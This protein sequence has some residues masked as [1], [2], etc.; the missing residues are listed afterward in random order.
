MTGP[1][2][3]VFPGP[4]GGYLDDSALRRR[5]KTARGQRRATATAVPRP[6]P[7]LR[8]P[9]HPH[10][11]PARTA[12]VDGPRRLRD[13][14]GLPVLHASRGRRPPTWR[15]VRPGP[16]G[17]IDHGPLTQPRALADE[18][19][20]IRATDTSDGATAQ[21]LA[22]SRA[23]VGRS[24]VWRRAMCGHR[25]GAPVWTDERR[26]GY[27]TMRARGKQRAPLCAVLFVGCNSESRYGT[28]GHDA[29]I[30]ARYFLAAVTAVKQEPSLRATIAICGQQL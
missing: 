6:T 23:M 20:E 9:R 14:R 30:A 26:S 29:A 1:D 28:S 3:L 12:G 4:L 18:T 24:R 11:R 17:D 22:T 13:Y 2:D 7:G 15:G 19:A 16:S 21:A 25:S 10:R 8:D 27:C 5:Y